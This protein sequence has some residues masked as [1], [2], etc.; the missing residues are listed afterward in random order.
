MTYLDKIIY[1]HRELAKDDTRSLD[2]LIE[3]ASDCEQPRPFSNAITSKNQTGNLAVI[4]EIKKAS[5]SKGDLER[6]PQI[7]S[8][9]SWASCYEEGQAAC[10]S[11]LTNTDFFKGSVEDLQQAKEATQLPVLRK[12]FTISP[13]DVVDA[14]LMGADAVLLIVAALDHSEL[15]DFFDLATEIGLDV[16]VET[17]DESEVENALSIGAEIIGINQRD[18]ETFEVDSTRAIRVAQEIPEE[19]IKI[20]ESG[21]KDSKDALAM[22]DAGFNGILVGESIVISK[23][24]LKYLEELTNI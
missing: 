22:K 10:I 20:A 5:P 3:K 14:R 23:E 13:N 16:L 15:K 11:V 17:H 6:S 24:P 7:E 12:D 8:I 1:H 19:K 2:Q 18:L 4:A 9:E 21:I